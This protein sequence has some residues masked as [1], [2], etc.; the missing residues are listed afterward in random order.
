MHKYLN[1]KFLLFFFVIRQKRE[2]S[3]RLED[4]QKDIDLLDSG[5][6]I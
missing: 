1:N 6:F 2:N 3:A 5:I 4:T